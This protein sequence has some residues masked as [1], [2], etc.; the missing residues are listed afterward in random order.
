VKRL[1][2]LMAAVTAG[3]AMLILAPP[4][5]AEAGY[6]RVGALSCHVAPGIGII[7][8][9]R[10]PMECVYEPRRGPTRYLTGRI[11]RVGVDVGFTGPQLLAWAVL[12]ATD[13]PEY[14]LAGGYGGVSA[15]ATAIL[16]VGANA[17]VGGNQDA[18][19]LQPISLTAQ[20]GLNLAVGVTGLRLYD[21]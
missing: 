20:V 14:S 18:V 2:T 13:T 9:S 7:I 6:V 3:L 4:R 16:G 11:T 10:K 17:L 19:V 8:A 5:Q 1:I 12:V 15:Q 21:R